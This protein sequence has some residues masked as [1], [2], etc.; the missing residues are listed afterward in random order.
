MTVRVAIN[1]FGR[2]G[3]QVVRRVIQSEADVDVVVVNSRKARPEICAH[4][5]QYDSV[6]GRYPGEISHDDENL[7]VDGRT[8]RVT[9]RPEPLLCFWRA[10]DIDV[11][12][13]AT[14]QFTHRDDAAYHLRAGARK[15]LVTAPARFEDLTVVVGVNDHLYDPDRHHVVSAGSCTTNCL[16]PMLTVLH[17]SFGVE[18]AL[19]TSIHAFTRDQQL[20]DGTHHDL[21]RARAAALNMTPTKTGAAKAIDRV[22]PQL[23]GRVVGI[24]V[25][26]PVPDVSLVDLSVTLTRPT[27]M[28]QINDAFRNAAAGSMAG[29]LGVTDEPLVSTDFQGDTRSAVIDLASTRRGPGTQAKVLGWYD[30]EAGY[31]ARVVDLC[32]LLGGSTRVHCLSCRQPPGERRGSRRAAGAPRGALPPTG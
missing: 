27:T 16:A 19:V 4:L 24:A 6:L 9:D 11:V 32:E 21:R 17:D 1:G 8:I 15:V 3:R 10:F 23:A 12:V 30:N 5:L 14:G 22:L 18:G 13:E 26:V 7:V 20:L 25:R 31:A 29:V 28:G 2:I